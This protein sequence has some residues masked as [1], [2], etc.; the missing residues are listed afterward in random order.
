MTAVHRDSRNEHLPNLVVPLSDF[1]NGEIWVEQGDG[2]VW[3]TSLLGHGQAFS[4][5]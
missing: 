2:D 4:W 5:R 1:Q 3:E